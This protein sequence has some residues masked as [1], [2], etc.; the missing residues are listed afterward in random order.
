MAGRQ[1]RYRL[2][3]ERLRA[4]AVDDEA[5]PRTNK[6]LVAVRVPDG[7][8]SRKSLVINGRRPFAKD[9]D[10]LNYDYD[11]EEKWGEETEG[12]DINSKGDQGDDEGRD[13]LEYDE[14][15]CR[16]DDYGIDVDHDAGTHSVAQNGNIVELAGPRFINAPVVMAFKRT[17]SPDNDHHTR[18][19]VHHT[20]AGVGNVTYVVR[21]EGAWVTRPLGD[22]RDA[23]ILM[24]Y[25]AVAFPSQP[26]PHLGRCNPP[27]IRPELPKPNGFDQS[28]LGD[29]VRHIHGSKHGFAKLTDGFH[30]KKLI[31][32][33]LTEIAT[34]RKSTDGH[35]TAR[36]MVKEDVL[37][38]LGMLQP[39]ADFESPDAAK[40]IAPGPQALGETGDYT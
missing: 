22:D 15:L 1:A 36:W 24:K 29:L 12:E 28:T 11:S 7:T 27:D 3:A 5:R 33:K 32:K 14:F 37:G 18:A 30:D 20:R 19:G 10:L 2:R 17:S 26:P 23:N 40:S 16:D 13:E 38:H 4:V 34:K 35:G 8:I 39:E 31:K 21:E 9:I 6:L 25:D